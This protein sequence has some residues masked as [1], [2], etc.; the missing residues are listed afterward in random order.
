MKAIETEFVVF[1]LFLSSP[2]TSCTR[3]LTI[4]VSCKIVWPFEDVVVVVGEDK[5]TAGI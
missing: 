2:L 4:F 1:S 3:P 5:L